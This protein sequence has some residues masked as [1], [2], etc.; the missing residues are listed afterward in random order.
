MSRR[1]RNDSPFTLFAFQDIITSVTGIL[2]LITLIL[3]LSIVDKPLNES[4]ENRENVQA[5]K[6]QLASL[7]ADVNSLEQQTTSDSELLDL[8]AQFGVEGIEDLNQALS[9]AIK[10]TKQ[11]LGAGAIA[12]ASNGRKAEQ[13]RD[14]VSRKTADLEQIARKILEQRKLLEEIVA[15][16]R[17]AYRFQGSRGDEPWIIDVGSDKWLAAPANKNQKPVVFAQKGLRQRLNSLENW[18]RSASSSQKYM[19]LLVRPDGVES[20]SAIRES[21]KLAGTSFGVDLIPS[22]ITVIDSETGAVIQ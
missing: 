14:Q 22:D 18:Y 3:A 1:K 4:S 8:M 7:Q 5:L 15:S 11:M 16:N 6:A 12:N 13:V 20:Y 17:V 21:K 2:I 19:V 9:E 10:K